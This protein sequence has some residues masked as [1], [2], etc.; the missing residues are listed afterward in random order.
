MENQN[1]PYQTS[2]ESTTPQPSNPLPRRSPDQI[3]TKAGSFLTNKLFLI[4]LVI[5]IVFTAVYAGIY[6]SLNSKLNQITKSNPTPIIPPS[7]SPA[8]NGDRANWKTYTDSKN[9]FSLKYPND[10]TINIPPSQT[11]EPFAFILGI[12]NS[13]SFILVLAGSI[14]K[15]G[16]DEW[17]NL[18]AMGERPPDDELIEKR[19]LT[20][21]TV[22][23]EGEVWEH[24]GAGHIVTTIENRSK[25]YQIVAFFQSNKEIVL[26]DF[27]QI[28]STFQFTK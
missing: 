23:A 3:G 27:D 1:E 15:K 26:R 18:R 13:Q 7:A 6:L 24:E 2:P 17:R 14:N 11:E 22:E 21:D 9:G 4:A 5:L 20:I 19:R 28:L 16:L 12:N 10:W 25:V 8:P